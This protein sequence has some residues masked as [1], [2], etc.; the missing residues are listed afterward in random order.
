VGV[1]V[2]AALTIRLRGDAD[3][4][5]L[6]A[7]AP[8][9]EAV[10]LFAASSLAWPLTPQRLAEVGQAPGRT[11]WVLVD[12]AEPSVPLAHA[13]LTVSGDRARIGR[14]IVDPAR[15]GRRLGTTVVRLVGDEARRAGCARLDLLVIDG[16]TAAFRTYEGLGFAYDL[17]SDLDGMVAMTLRLGAPMTGVVM[18]SAAGRRA[19]TTRSTIR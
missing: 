7:W 9:R 6:S 16:N 4:P 1:T 18:T 8:D 3:L 13:D 12:T 11:S 2:S 15:R 14:V 10:R 17:A 19:E 5:V